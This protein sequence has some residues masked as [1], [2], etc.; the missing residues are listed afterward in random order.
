MT[1]QPSDKNKSIG[2]KIKF[3]REQ[4]DLTQSELG[5]M[6][7]ISQN[8]INC[9]ENKNWKNPS[10]KVVAKL[11]EALSVPI[12]YL[13]DENCQVLDGVDE[14]V[15]LVKFRKLN[16]KDRKLIIEIVEIFLK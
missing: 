11:A 9:Y 2:Q 7:G 3:R 15:L 14:E 10:A 12:I 16:L 4:L 13:L 8:T 6:L 1:K 5:K